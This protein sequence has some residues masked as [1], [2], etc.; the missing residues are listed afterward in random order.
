M[1][2]TPPQSFPFPV[3]QN[4]TTTGPGVVANVSPSMTLQ[5]LTK[6]CVVTQENGVFHLRVFRESGMKPGSYSCDIHGFIDGEWK[7][8][9]K[10]PKKYERP[11]IPPEA[12]PTQVGNQ[13]FWTLGE[14]T[15]EMKDELLRILPELDAEK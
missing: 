6:I 9:R 12:T 10:D 3:W 2:K 7:Y 14:M 8:L 5:G 15:Q 4:A 1:S 13:T 11:E